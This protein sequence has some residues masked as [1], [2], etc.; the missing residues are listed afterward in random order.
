MKTILILFVFIITVTM[1]FLTNAEN[2]PCTDLPNDF[3]MIEKLTKFMTTLKIVANNKE[4]GTVEKKFTFPAEFMFKD[5]QGKVLATAKENIIAGGKEVTIVDPQGKK[6]G[7]IRQNI[8]KQLFSTKEFSSFDIF[9]ANNNKIATSN[10]FDFGST[11]IS[12]K[13][14]DGT[15]V[16]KI[17]RPWYKQGLLADKWDVTFKNTQKVDPRIL[18]M[19]AAQKTA[20]DNKKENQKAWNELLK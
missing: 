18:V 4:Y 12:I 1:S 6:I 9:D 10:K 20:Y 7:I 2:P 14:T 5:S 13:A 19:I 16:A 11:L 3:Q 17:E 15:A 8:A